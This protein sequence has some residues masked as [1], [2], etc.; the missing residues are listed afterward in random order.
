MLPIATVDGKGTTLIDAV[1]TSTSALCVTGLVVRDTP[2]Y[3]SGFGQIVILVLIQLGGL[4][5][6]DVVYLPYY[7]YWQTAS[8]LSTGSHKGCA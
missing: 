8:Y 7:G 4:G 1:F 5:Y 2:V 6:N 3:F